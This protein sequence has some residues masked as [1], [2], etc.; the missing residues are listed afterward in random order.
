[1]A[2]RQQVVEQAYKLEAG[3]CDCRREEDGGEAVRVHVTRAQ[4]RVVGRAH[5]VGLLRHARL[6]KHCHQVLNRLLQDV[7]RG[8]VHLCD[9]K[10]GWHL[11]RQRY[12][13]MLFAHAH[14]AHVGADH[15]ACVVGHV[16]CQPVG[17][18]PKVLF[19]TGEVDKRDD[20]CRTANVLP[21]RLVAEEAV[22]K[23]GAAGVQ[24]ERVL[25]DGRRASRRLLVRKLEDLGARE[26]PAVVEHRAREDTHHGGLAAVD[27]SDD[28]HANL[29]RRRVALGDRRELAHQHIGSKA[30][31]CAGGRAPPLHLAGPAQHAGRRAARLGVVCDHLEALLQ[32]LT[33]QRGRAMPI[34]RAKLQHYLAHLLQLWRGELERV[35]HHRAPVVRAWAGCGA[36][37]HMD[38]GVPVRRQERCSIRALS[39]MLCVCACIHLERWVAIAAIII[40]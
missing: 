29:G 32:L 27:V 7:L 11:E 25:P 14:D 35:L 23:D 26:A 38:A 37:R 34:W 39:S 22:V 31:L 36:R 40:E 5:K 16:A 21:A 6:L 13:Q 8:D 19:V 33:C 17:R 28:R 4:E 20:L 18:R 2:L 12:P 30:G 15:K 10:E 24:A 3:A 1:M 9:D